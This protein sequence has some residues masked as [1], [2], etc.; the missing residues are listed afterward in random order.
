M[1]NDFDII[2]FLI[3]V[4]MLIF[5]A[6]CI[7]GDYLFISDVI[8]YWNTSIFDI[9]GTLTFKSIFKFIYVFFS[10]CCTVGMINVIIN[11]IINK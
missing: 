8:K 7:Y 3:D 9:P 6:I 11:D 1:I 5:I 10:I 2:E 4:F